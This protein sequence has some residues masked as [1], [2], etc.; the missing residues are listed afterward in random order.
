MAKKE[1]PALFICRQGRLH[2][3]H[4]FYLLY[5]HNR[6][7]DAKRLMVLNGFA[8]FPLPYPSIPYPAFP[9]L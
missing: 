5:R 3:E 1:K 9:D 4:M 7:L 2:K 6:T 8:V